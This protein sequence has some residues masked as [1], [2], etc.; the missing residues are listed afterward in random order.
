MRAAKNTWISEYFNLFQKDRRA[1][2]IPFLLA[3]LFSLLPK[4]FPVLVKATNCWSSILP[5]KTQL[6]Q[7]EHPT[8]SSS[9]DDRDDSN[10][11][12]WN[13][14]HPLYH[15]STSV[16]AAELFYFWSQHGNH[17]RV[18]G[19][20]WGK[21]FKLSWIFVPKVGKFRKP[22]DLSKI[23]GLRTVTMND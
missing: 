1:V 9:F 10:G 20:S 8:L 4:L 11:E 18:E 2:A 6:V 7:N 22:E 14:N 17:W 16:T 21:P 19:L 13:L 23:Y 5:H 15:T 12:Y 3:V